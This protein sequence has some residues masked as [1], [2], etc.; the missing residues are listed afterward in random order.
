MKTWPTRCEIVVKAAQ[1]I[2][3]DQARKRRLRAGFPHLLA[4]NSESSR[5]FFNQ[6]C[7]LSSLPHWMPIFKFRDLTTGARKLH[8]RGKA[9][10]Q[11]IESLLANP[12]ALD[13]FE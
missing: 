1:E 5:P 3:T 6:H 13:L 7:N 9:N 11:L 12:S 8:K 4:I 10:A 2:W